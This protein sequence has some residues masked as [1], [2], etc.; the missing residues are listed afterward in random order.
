[1]SIILI[2]AQL[3]LCG[4]ATPFLV[5]LG[6][7]RVATSGGV[8]PAV[9]PRVLL[10]LES[11]SYLWFLVLLFFARVIGPDYSDLRFR[12]IYANAAGMLGIGVVAGLRGGQARVPLLWAAGLLLVLWL[13]A[14]SVSSVV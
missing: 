2:W 6:W 3:L 11:V 5:G 7:R 10:T 13:Y 12:T 9:L 8:R 1:M 4:V 14:A